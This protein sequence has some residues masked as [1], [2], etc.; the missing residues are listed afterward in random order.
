[1]QFEPGVQSA[2]VQSLVT[3]HAAQR[4]AVQWV[5][6]QVAPVAQGVPL[7][8]ATHAPVTQTSPLQSASTLHWTQS[9]EQWVEAHWWSWVQGVPFSAG[10]THA[11]AKQMLPPLQSV[12]AMQWTQTAF[13]Q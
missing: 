8:A 2:W 5:D 7:G 3:E 13:T 6:W 4:P 10:A 12:S 1:V 11:P 9:P